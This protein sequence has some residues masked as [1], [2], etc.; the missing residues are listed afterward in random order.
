MNHRSKMITIAVLC[1][2]FS[3]LFCWAWFVLDFLASFS[4]SDSS[5]LGHWILVS[6]RLPFDISK[7]FITLAALLVMIASAITV[8]LVDK[9]NAVSKDSN[10]PES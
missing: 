2:G 10:A 7:V 3:L 1:A 5:F 9:R 8:V 6:Q 4:V